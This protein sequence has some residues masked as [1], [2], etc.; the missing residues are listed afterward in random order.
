M[1]LE[2]V[3]ILEVVVFLDDDHRKHPGVDEVLNSVG[4]RVDGKVRQQALLGGDRFH[5]DT[6]EGHRQVAVRKKFV[7][8][9]RFGCADL[10]I[11]GKRI[12]P[13][14]LKTTG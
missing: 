3:L 6:F 2:G 8:R 5:S 11:I 14:T 10:K 9:K 12:V 1:H 13:M 7:L 4:Y